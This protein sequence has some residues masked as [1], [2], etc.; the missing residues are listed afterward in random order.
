[1]NDSTVVE[2]LRALAD[3][4]RLSIVRELRGGTRCACELARF[5]DVSSPLL[6]HH[7]KVLRRAGLVTGERRGRWIDYTLD[8]QAFEALVALL[9]APVP[10]VDRVATLGC[11]S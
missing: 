9:D 5:A 4:V 11:A 2:Q 6:S 3:P 8:E 7:L 1:V 10:T